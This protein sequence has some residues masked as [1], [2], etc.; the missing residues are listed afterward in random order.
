M[1]IL[2]TF[3]AITALIA[4]SASFAQDTSTNIHHTDPKAFIIKAD[5]PLELKDIYININQAGTID[6]EG[7]IIGKG[8]T[9]EVDN[10]D[11]YCYNNHPLFLYFEVD[12]FIC[13]SHIGKI[14]TFIEILEANGAGHSAVV[15]QHTNII[16]ALLNV[17]TD[18]YK[19]TV[20]GSA[21]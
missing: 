14:H 15:S 4:S 5:N 7:V 10:F 20:I 3:F 9:D 2:K 8:R 18:G 17:K 6:G 13:M 21:Q 12:G 11:V 16:D 19:A 1:E